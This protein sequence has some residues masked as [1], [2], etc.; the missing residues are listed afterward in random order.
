MSVTFQEIVAAI[1]AFEHFDHGDA[2]YLFHSAIE[3]LGDGSGSLT[4]HLNRADVP[5]G[6]VGNLVSAL[7]FGAIEKVYEFETEEAMMALLA[8]PLKLSVST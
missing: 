6:P 2:Y 5:S 3:I 1:D 4:V 7:G 8:S